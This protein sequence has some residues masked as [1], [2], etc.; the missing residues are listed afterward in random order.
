MSRVLIWGWFGF[1]NLGDDL[2]FKTMQ[3]YLYGDITVPMNTQYILPGVKQIPRSYK[4]LVVG[5]LDNDVLIIGPGGLFPFDNKIKVL[6]YYIAGRIWKLR[7]RKVVFFGIGISERMSNF[8]AMLW[9]R[10]AMRADLFIPRSENVL[11]RIGLDETEKIHA[12]SDTVFASN[13]AQNQNCEDSNRVVISVAN[14]QQDNEEIFKDAVGK[15]IH[16][17]KELLERGFMVDLIAFTK[18]KDDRM[19]DAIA[20]STKIVREKV[21]LIHYNDAV[22]SVSNWNQYKF[23]ICMRFHSLVLS[24][25]TGVP[26]I[27]IAYGH[28]TFALAEKCGLEDY[29][30]IWNNF[31][32]K[33]YG[34]RIDISSEQIIEKTEQLCGNLQEIKEKIEIRRKGFINSASES[35]AQLLNVI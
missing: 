6:L 14:L 31:Q 10:I 27:P 20:S 35:F 26:A 17:V 16:V 21:R 28:K 13:I 34:E 25:L 8:S 29:V 11:K 2:L 23:A 1:E 4:S 12:M 32:D 3:Q 7:G 33:Y 9:R 15:W 18:G 30:L 22:D 24:I 19:I 5:A